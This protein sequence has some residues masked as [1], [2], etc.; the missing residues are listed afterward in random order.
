M[1]EKSLNLLRAWIA[2]TEELIQL[3]TPPAPQMPPQEAPQMPQ[4]MASPQISELPAIA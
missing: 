3:A 1:G 2:R 4:E